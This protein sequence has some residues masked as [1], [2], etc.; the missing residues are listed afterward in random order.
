LIG[1]ERHDVGRP[2]DEG[3]PVRGI[4]KN[5]YL[6]IENFKPDRWPSGNPETGYLNCDG[7]PTKTF[8]LNHQKTP[9]FEKYWQWSFGKRPA[10]E[11]YKIDKDPFCINDLAGEN[12][13]KL[14]QE[15]LRKQMYEELTAQGDPRI[16][17]RGDIFDQY[18]DASQAAGFYE[19]FMQGEKVSAGWVNESDFELLEKA[20]TGGN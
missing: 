1:K 4:I 16:L 9:E 17:G 13:T 11:L 20:D 19:R 18:P 7:S 14:M 2:D 10:V 12:S 8:I 15:E 5:D 6:Y 3:Y